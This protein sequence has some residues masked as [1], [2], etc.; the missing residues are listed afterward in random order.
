MLP[1]AWAVEFAKTPIVNSLHIFEIL[2]F[3]TGMNFF[4]VVKR[5][6]SFAFKVTL[7]YKV[8]MC[9]NKKKT[10]F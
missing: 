3:L 5:A 7:P 1:Y 10:A 4:T 8:W 2:E 6:A 9:L